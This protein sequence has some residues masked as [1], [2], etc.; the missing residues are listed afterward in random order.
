MSF[1]TF[2]LLVV[3]TTALMLSQTTFARP[4]RDYGELL[5]VGAPAVTTTTKAPPVLIPVSPDYN[6]DK[7]NNRQGNNS[8]NQPNYDNKERKKNQQP[9]Y[10]GYNRTKDEGNR[11]KYGDINNNNNNNRSKQGGSTYEVKYNY[12]DTFSSPT[13]S[14]TTQSSYWPRETV[15]DNYRERNGE[16]NELRRKD[17]LSRRQQQQLLKYQ[18]QQRKR[19][20]SSSTTTTTTTSS[21]VLNFSNFGR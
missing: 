8:Y 10:G 12:E 15:E 11:S 9:N 7:D 18:E 2:F 1:L 20:N 17:E 3:S 14:T 19:A 6:H 16:G 5:P 13:T 4:P 21:S